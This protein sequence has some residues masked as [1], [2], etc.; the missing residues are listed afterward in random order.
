M[1]A[2]VCL[3]VQLSTP[4]AAIRALLHCQTHRQIPV[5][6]SSVTYDAPPAFHFT[7]GAPLSRLPDIPNAPA[8]ASFASCP[9]WRHLYSDITLCSFVRLAFARQN[10]SLLHIESGVF[11]VKPLPQATRPWRLLDLDRLL[12]CFPVNRT[13]P[14]PN[15]TSTD[16]VPQLITPLH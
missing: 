8:T 5:A 1:P 3:A 15:T 10:K 4:S 11:V 13:P 12:N 16:S 7:A 6:P 2:R 9:P 14:V